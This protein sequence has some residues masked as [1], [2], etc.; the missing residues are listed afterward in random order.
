MAS[1]STVIVHDIPT[2]ANEDFLKNLF[3]EFGEV[4]PNGITIKTRTD[5]N[6]R[7]FAFA[8][9]QFA[10]HDTALRVIAEMNYTKLD[11][12]P[13]RI[14]TA[15][16]ETKAIQRSGQG[17]LFVKNL[18]TAIEDS[19]LHEA[20][21]NFGDIVSC[22]ITKDEHGMSQGYGYVQFRHANDAQQAMEDL[23][24]ASIN[25]RPLEIQPFLRRRPRL[26]EESFTNVYIKNLPPSI[27]DDAALRRLFEEFGEVTSPHL[28]VDE[29]G[30]S[31]GFAH[32]NMADH[33]SAVR[34]VE[35]LNGRTVDNNVL[36]AGRAMSRHE[37]QQKLAEETERWRRRQYELYKGRN[38]YVRGFDDNMTSEDL[39]RIF[40]EFGAVEST[41]VSVNDDGTSRKFGYVCFEDVGSAQRAIQ[42]SVLLKVGDKGFYVSEL[43]PKTDRKRENLAKHAQRAD[44]G[45]MPPGHDPQ[46]MRGGLGPQPQMPPPGYGPA[47]PGA[48][49]Q[50]Y[51]PGMGAGGYQAGIPHPANFQ[52]DQYGA[53]F[54]TSPMGQPPVF[55]F[56]VTLSPRDKIRNELIERFGPSCPQL[57]SLQDLS[58]DQ[59]KRLSGDQQLLN[60]WLS[61]A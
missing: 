19:Q 22:K 26:P 21:A 34:A 29:N 56:P 48:G 59:V 37:R 57:K 36:F 25:G 18:D 58:D 4:R 5:R 30:A 2:S 54:M 23:K 3:A 47:H 50:A 35:G 9:V 53:P 49:A 8:F 16:P 60:Q 17:N 45:A 55:G 52:Q 40:S 39:A 38:L 44:R 10:D 1:T 12:Q 11:G 24:E 14:V 13:I 61:I 41:K 43:V 51:M 27:E 15:D 42:G 33:E 32:C 28:E 7:Q 31:R 6:G 20:F 46:G